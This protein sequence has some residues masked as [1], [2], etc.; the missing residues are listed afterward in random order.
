MRTG[1]AHA[2][3]SDRGPHRVSSM[4]ALIAFESA[5]RHGSFSHAARELGT[6]QSAISRLIARLE[7][8][9]S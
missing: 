7:D 1:R 6:S 8:E 2:P 5:A 4:S 9:L 3:L